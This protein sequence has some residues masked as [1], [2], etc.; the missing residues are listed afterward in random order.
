MGCPK[1]LV[2]CTINKNFFPHTAHYYSTEFFATVV[3]EV[4]VTIVFR[5]GIQQILRAFRPVVDIKY[6][7]SGV[8]FTGSL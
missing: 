5:K 2:K 8:I 3:L 4:K 6:S 1:K 7:N